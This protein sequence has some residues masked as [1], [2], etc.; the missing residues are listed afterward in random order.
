[1]AKVS[2]RF[3]FLGVSTS[4]TTTSRS[5]AYH[6]DRSVK[7][8]ADGLD[9]VDDFFNDDEDDFAGAPPAIE[10]YCEAVFPDTENQY[11]LANRLFSPA[12]KPNV[13]PD[14]STDKKGTS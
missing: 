7:V 8:D 5:Q 11:H 6:L 4:L 2:S 14:T 10:E 1:M 9:N 13:T 12:T 3:S